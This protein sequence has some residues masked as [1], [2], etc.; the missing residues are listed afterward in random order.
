MRDT[1]AFLSSVKVDFGI[2]NESDCLNDIWLQATELDREI[3]DLQKLIIDS[4]NAIEE[5]W[6]EQ[7]TAAFEL[8]SVFM[9]RG[10]FSCVNSLFSIRF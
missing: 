8:V 1:F 6:K 5:L 7:K 2:K 4:R 9:H 3:L 10:Q